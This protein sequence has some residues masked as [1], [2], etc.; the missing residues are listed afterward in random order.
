MSPIK[1]SIADTTVAD[2]IPY[3][4]TTPCSQVSTNTSTPQL[5]TAT[6]LKTMITPPSGN[7]SLTTPPSDT[8]SVESPIGDLHTMKPVARQ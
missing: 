6:P 8:S 5:A 3:T 1:D 4:L 7:K 2:E